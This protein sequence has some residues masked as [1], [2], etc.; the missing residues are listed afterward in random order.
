[1]TDHAL[2]GASAEHIEHAV[3]TRRRNSDQVD[4][5]LDGGVHD[6]IHDVARPQNDRRKGVRIC[7]PD[8]QRRGL[9][10]DVQDMYGGFRPAH[11]RAEP[12][13]VDQCSP[14][15][16]RKI[17][18]DEHASELDISVHLADETSCPWGD[19]S[20]GTAERRK[21]DSATDPLSQCSMP[22][23]P[24]VASTTRSLSCSLRKSMIARVGSC[25]ARRILSTSIPSLS[26]TTDGGS[27]SFDS[28]HCARRRR[29]CGNAN[30]S[31]ASYCDTC[32]RCN[33]LLVANAIRKA[34]A[35]AA[36][37]RSEKSVGCTMER[38]EGFI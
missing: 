21:T 28:P 15:P 26:A 6:R 35:N 14:G 3:M 31:W 4:V 25:R 29:A 5:E 37:L 27:S 18:R 36:T 2:G 17:H 20:V 38:M 1:M 12:V 9:V 19:D 8:V 10:A 34:W 7:R 33:L 32:T 11:Q 30:A 22:S 24:W 13:N 16:R 23:R